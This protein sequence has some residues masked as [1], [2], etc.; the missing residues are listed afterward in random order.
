MIN[1]KL[2]QLSP[3]PVLQ[4]CMGKTGDDT[5]LKGSHDHNRG[6]IYIAPVSLSYTLSL[7]LLGLLLYFSAQSLEC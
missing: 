1:I 7:A 4:R 2:S 3:I 6:K 5:Y